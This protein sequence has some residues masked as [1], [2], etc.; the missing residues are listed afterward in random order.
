VGTG[1][2]QM[3][4]SRVNG[5]RLAQA[6]VAAALATALAACGG[7]SAPAGSSSTQTAQSGASPSGTAGAT[8]ASSTQFTPIVEPFDPGHPA[9][10]S[11]APASCGG[12]QTTL[13]ITQCF[14]DRTENTDA[15]IDT[16]QLAHY[17]S[18]SPSQRAAILAEDAAWLSAR[19]PVC[20]LAFHSGG[21]IDGINVASCLLDESIARLNAVKGVIPAEATL[22]ATDNPNPSALAWYTTPAGSRIAMLDTQGDQSGGTIISWVIIGGAD[23]FIINPRQFYFRDGSFTD[24]GVLQAPNP[25]SH[26]VATGVQYQF[27]IDYSHLSA[28]PNAAKGA[29][30]YAYAPGAPVAIWR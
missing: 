30:G 7:S 28:D 15:A 19:R 22:K 9:R 14:E 29:G 13:A 16:V 20:A 21:T 4:Q 12:Q 23:G 17:T 25:T 1:G 8:T 18:G 26:R 24:Q 2:G 10:S 11:P 5:I 27:G 3:G 6:A